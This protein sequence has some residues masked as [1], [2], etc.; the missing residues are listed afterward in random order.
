[1]YDGYGTSDRKP[2]KV[3]YSKIQIQKVLDA[4]PDFSELNQTVEDIKKGLQDFKAHMTTN[5]RDQKKMVQNNKLKLKA[6]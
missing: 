6:A 5:E 3:K 1:M 2:K 4:K